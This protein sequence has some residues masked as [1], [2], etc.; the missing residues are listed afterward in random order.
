MELADYTEHAAQHARQLGAVEVH[1]CDVDAIGIRTTE[2]GAA[3]DSY[4]GVSV[5][6]STETLRPV[7]AIE[8]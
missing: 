8:V 4:W 2:D 6:R 3:F 1:A 7:A 5:T